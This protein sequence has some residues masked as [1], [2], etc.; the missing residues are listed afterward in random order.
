[1]Q[2]SSKIIADLQTQSTDQHRSAQN[3]KYQQD[4]QRHR[5]YQY[6][7]ATTQISEIYF[8]ATPTMVC[9][10]GHCR[11]HLPGS[12]GAGQLSYYVLTWKT[13]ENP[14]G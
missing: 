12:R 11:D 14:M 1:M 6:K 2:K 7:S 13:E 4:M 9:I 8:K 5:A 3:S 10:I